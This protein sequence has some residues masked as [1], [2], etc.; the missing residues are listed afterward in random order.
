[1]KTIITILLPL[2][3]TTPAWAGRITLKNLKSIAAGLFMAVTAVVMTAT[4]VMAA[5]TTA[6]TFLNPGDQYRLAFLTQGKINGNSSAISTYNNFV[7][8]QANTEAALVALSTTWTAI[9]STNGSDARVTTGTASG[10]GVPIFLLDVASTRIAD[11]NADLW[12]GSIY[13]PLNINQYGDLNPATVAWTGSESNGLRAPGQSA[14]GN[15][16][17]RIGITTA[18]NGT[19]I[20][21]Q[22]C[23]AGIGFQGASQLSIYALSGVLE[24][25]AATVPEAG[26]LSLLTLGLAG[27]WIVRRKRIG[28]R[29]L[30]H[31]PLFISKPLIVA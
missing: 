1:M 7:T 15:S 14:L 29:D 23:Y 12:D 10:V 2:G 31:E 30:S 22:C 21:N 3:I 18:V 24:T 13:N 25:P 5:P 9:L 26:S 6:P 17:S 4:P 27:L 28:K 19:W 16:I 11:N 20:S 8:S